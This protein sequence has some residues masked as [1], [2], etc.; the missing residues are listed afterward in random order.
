MATTMIRFACSCVASLTLLSTGCATVVSKSQYPV[1]VDNRPAPTYFTVYNQKNEIVHQGV[2]PQKIT[3]PAKSRPFLPAKYSVVLA[4]EQSTSQRHA[5]NAGFDPWIAG[6]LVLG[7]GLGAIVDGAT[8]AMFKL[9]EQVVG[10]LDTQYAVT[11]QQ[12]GSMILAGSA[13]S[14]G[15][16][17]NLPAGGSNDPNRVIPVSAT[18]IVGRSTPIDR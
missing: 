5:L 14:K 9:P 13:P 18:T 16:L 4:G 1:L 17:N 7:G 12:R 15:S 2:T 3:L 11:D 6:N 10:N 8:G